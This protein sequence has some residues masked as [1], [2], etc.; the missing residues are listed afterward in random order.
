MKKIFLIVLF[1]VVTIYCA[2]SNEAKLLQAVDNEDLEEVQRLVMIPGI[3][4]RA[5]L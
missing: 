3:N 4:L 5:Y 1:S 2:E